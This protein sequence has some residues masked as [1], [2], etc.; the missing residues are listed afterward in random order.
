M[1]AMSLISIALI[2]SDQALLLYLSFDF[3]GNDLLFVWP[4]DSVVVQ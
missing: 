4:P 3:G 1:F 2:L